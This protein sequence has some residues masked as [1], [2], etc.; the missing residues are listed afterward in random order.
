MIC[1]SF[2]IEE[3]DMPL[4]Y[5][6]NI[7]FEQQITTS[8]NG[9]NHVLNLLDKYKIPATFFSTVTFAKNSPQLIERIISSGHELASHTY[10][11]SE[12]SIEHL[13]SSKL[14]LEKLSGKEIIGL[15]MPRM[16]FVPAKD[17]TEAGYTYNSSVNPTYLPGRYDNRHI[18]RTIFTEKKLIQIPAS[19]S[20][21]LRIPLFWLSF[22]NFPL[23][24]YK[25]L[26]LKTYKK[27]GY[28][29]LYFHPWEFSHIAKKE[30]QLPFYTT[31]NTHTKMITR[32]DSLLRWIQVHRI[33]TGTLETLA[34]QYALNN[35][36]T[37][38]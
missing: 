17:V 27:D 21:Y 13:L 33:P 10:Y 9:L 35:I 6:G 25:Y 37:T 24:L 20:P 38:E 5:R 29:N 16:M 26:L 7:S 19:V 3:F 22:H 36:K 34:K 1:L 12:F 28:A 30:F 31:I 32:F 14:E 18:S 2:D 8:Q 15:R 11:H 4:E 23:W